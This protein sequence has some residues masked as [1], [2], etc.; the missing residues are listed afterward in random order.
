M[1]ETFVSGTPVDWNITFWKKKRF[2]DY[3]NSLETW[4]FMQ[5]TTKIFRPDH[6]AASH[7]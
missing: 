3:N 5:T 4:G 7:G 1:A 6:I 2:P